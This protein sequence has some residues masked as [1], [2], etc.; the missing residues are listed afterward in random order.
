MSLPHSVAQL[1]Q[2]LDRVGPHV[3][4]VRHDES[5][6]IKATQRRAVAQDRWDWAWQPVDRAIRVTALKASWR[7][8]L[9]SRP[10]GCCPLV[11][12]TQRQIRGTG[13]PVLARPSPNNG[14][15]H[16]KEIDDAQQDEAKHA[17][18]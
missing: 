6:R 5:R 2:D 12:R 18:Q 11:I 9:W 1:T 16:R 10:R 8:L 15:D 4:I 14:P 3:I 13:V 17:T 7:T